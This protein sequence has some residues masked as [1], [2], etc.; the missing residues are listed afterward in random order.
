MDTNLIRSI[1]AD[2][3]QILDNEANDKVLNQYHITFNSPENNEVSE[4]TITLTGD[5]CVKVFTSV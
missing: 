3:V 4:K 5:G 1:K 2:T